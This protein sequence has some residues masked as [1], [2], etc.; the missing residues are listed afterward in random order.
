MPIIY[1]RSYLQAMDA[2][3]DDNKLL[4]MPRLLAQAADG[5]QLGCAHRAGQL[6][7]NA[8]DNRL[9]D[10]VKITFYALAIHECWRQNVLIFIFDNC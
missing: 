10:A 9:N 7:S 2:N 1:S 8:L 3:Y 6:R 5:V 4:E